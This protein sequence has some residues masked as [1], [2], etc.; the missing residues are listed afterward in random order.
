MISIVPEQAGQRSLV[1]SGKWAD[2]LIPS[3]ERQCWRAALPS[4]VGE[5]AEMADANQAA[6]QNVKQEAAQELMSVNRHD[7]LLASVGIVSP[8]E[9]D[10]IVLEG[11]EP[12]VGDGDAMGIAGQIVED[13]L[14]AAEGR[15]GVDDPVLLEELP[16][17]AA[18]GVRR[19]KMFE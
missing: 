19:G 2:A 13:V 12:M 4:A 8:E 11:H 18:E 10:A 3:S 15:L 5:E 16:G 14:G 6:G 17:E 1:I 7:L 9:G